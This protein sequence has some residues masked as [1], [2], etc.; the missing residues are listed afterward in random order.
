[1]VPPLLFSLILE[2]DL[3]VLL[4]K[5]AL[6]KAPSLFTEAELREPDVIADRIM[7]FFYDTTR[8]PETIV[9]ITEDMADKYLVRQADDEGL[10]QLHTQPQAVSQSIVLAATNDDDDSTIIS[11]P[12]SNRC[13]FDH[14]LPE[15]FYC[16]EDHIEIGCSLGDEPCNGCSIEYGE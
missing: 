11:S 4:T 1:M 10:Q 16:I 14:S 5:G 3:L 7:T 8:E 9:P 2:F 12:K 13:P 6:H 15:S